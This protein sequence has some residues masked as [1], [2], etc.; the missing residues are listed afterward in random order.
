MMVGLSAFSSSLLT[1]L[2][3]NIAQLIMA[4]TGMLLLILRTDMLLHM[5]MMPRTANQH[6]LRGLPA[7]YPPR[8]LT[9]LRI[10]LGMR[11]FNCFLSDQV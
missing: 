10:S 11:D 7:G 4:F 6:P 3:K 1:R 5:D 9:S 2:A 8:I